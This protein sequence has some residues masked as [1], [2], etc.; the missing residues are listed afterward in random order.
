[1]T[2]KT[3]GLILTLFLFTAPLAATAQ[4]AKVYGIA[5]LSSV[6]RRSTAF[7]QALEQGLRELGYIEGQNLA[8]EYRNAE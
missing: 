6:N 3:G 5:Y 7:S 4:E 2:S 8:I 1:L